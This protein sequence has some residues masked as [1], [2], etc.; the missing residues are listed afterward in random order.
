MHLISLLDG[1][2]ISQ[3]TERPVVVVVV[4]AFES[5]KLISQE[6]KYPPNT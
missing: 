3:Q 5:R 1:D 4:V 6:L 2:V